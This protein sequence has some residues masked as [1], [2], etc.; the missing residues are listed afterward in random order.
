MAKMIQM[1]AY[2]RD[3]SHEQKWQ[4]A[5]F[6]DNF[7]FQ[8]IIR[9]YPDITKE[10]LVR[11]IP[12]L[13]DEELTFIGH[14]VRL[15]E[16]GKLKEN[17]LDI[18]IRTA[19]GKRIVFDMQNLWE[20]C[21]CGRMRIYGSN[22]DS[23]LLQKGAAD[24]C[25]PEVIVI[26]ICRFDPVG[27]KRYVYDTKP[28]STA[29]GS[30]WINDG[31]RMILLNAK[32]QKGPVSPGLKVFLDY[33]NGIEVNDP[34]CDNIDKAV[35]E[36]KKDEIVR[37]NYMT[38]SMHIEDERRDA[39]KKGLKEGRAEKEVSL[40]LENFK[41]GIPVEQ[42]AKFMHMPPEAVQKIIDDSQAL[43]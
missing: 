3:P 20:K 18:L 23:G 31:R 26:C 28:E 35:E 29:A 42:I 40:I 6:S 30:G 9:H 34:L 27:R 32:G 14:E 43:N 19:G 8:Y 41:D 17:S 10:I 15:G 4:Y 38:F 24:Y 33:V 37:R 22:V 11:I 5:G 21:M 1:P 39:R 13:R 12:E 16:S 36:M 7:V 25:V 2:I